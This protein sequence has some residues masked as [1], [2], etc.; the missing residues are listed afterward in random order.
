MKIK[1][2]RKNSNTIILEDDTAVVI[3]N[4]PTW[5][6]TAEK[7]LNYTTYENGEV[8]F[9]QAQFDTDNTTQETL[10]AERVEFA[11]LDKELDK[12]IKDKELGLVL[13]EAFDNDRYIELRDKL[14][15]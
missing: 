11:T 6:G 7:P 9:N 15:G 1:E 5:L 10:E 2:L 8:V 13:T 14:Y 3:E 12:R 4:W